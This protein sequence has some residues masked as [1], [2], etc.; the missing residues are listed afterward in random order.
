MKYLLSA[1]LFF[2]LFSSAE[3]GHRHY[4][5]R[6]H[7]VQRH[8]GVHHVR[9]YVR[10]AHHRRHRHHRRVPDL[11]AHHGSGIV[12]AKSGATARVAAH[13]AAAFQCVIDKLEGQGYPVRFMGGFARGGHI[14]G[15]LHYSGM[16]LDV[17][18]VARNVTRPA[19]P[20]NEITLANSCGLVSGAQWRWADSGHFQ[21]GGWTGRRMFARRHT[22]ERVSSRG[23]YRGV[24]RDT[25]VAVLCR[26]RLGKCI[27]PPPEPTRQESSANMM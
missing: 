1:L 21:M 8:H 13:V 24:A 12:R 3:A 6:A 5:H 25:A 16:A 26:H 19:M 23:R 22:R 11:R 18:Q 4:K 7:H 17:N 20:S 9:H 2:A 10:H 27:R 14:P 15:S